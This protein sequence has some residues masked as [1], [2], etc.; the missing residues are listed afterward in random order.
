MKKA[1]LITI[2]IVILSITWCFAQ[3]KDV[4]NRPLI[5]SKSQCTLLIDEASGIN[6][7]D[8]VDMSKTGVI[9][10]TKGVAVSAL[11]INNSEDTL[12]YAYCLHLNKLFVKTNNVEQLVVAD[13]PNYEFENPQLL[14]IPPHKYEL[15]YFRMTYVKPPEKDFK[16]KIGL[17]L[18][19]WNEKYKTTPPDITTIENADVVW[20]EEELM[21]VDRNNELMATTPEGRLMRA[22][23]V[24]DALNEDDY[25][26]YTLKRGINTLKKDVYRNEEYCKDKSKKYFDIPVRLTNSS[27]DTLKYCNMVKTGSWTTIYTTSDP[28]IAVPV[29]CSA[30]REFNTVEEIPPHHDTLFYIP[31]CFDPLFVK[32]GTKFRIGMALLKFRTSSQFSEVWEYSR[33]LAGLPKYTIWSDEV[34]VP[35]AK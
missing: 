18:L 35:E 32:R 19:K 17:H 5:Q 29:I 21:K 31:I 28:Q 9:P 20:S 13:E 1:L 14:A 27:N 33:L 3:V 10:L 25:K 34:E 2:P 16:F 7:S 15:I 24:Y 26:S 8:A 12:K 22:K 11:L 23:I 6:F 30:D 4:V